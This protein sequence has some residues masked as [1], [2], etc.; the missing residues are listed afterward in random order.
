MQIAY[1]KKGKERKETT[2]N[3]TGDV[4]NVGF[5]TTTMVIKSY[6]VL[7]ILRFSILSGIITI[8]LCFSDQAISWQS[9]QCWI[10]CFIWVLTMSTNK[11]KFC[12]QLAEPLSTLF[13]SFINHEQQ[14]LP[15]AVA[16]ITRESRYRTKPQK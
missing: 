14:Q 2:K 15:P 4:T 7:F 8:K 11:Y 1:F 9:R 5:I 16:T 6:L 3:K 13:F 12:W 10:E